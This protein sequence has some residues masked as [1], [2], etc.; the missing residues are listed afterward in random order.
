MLHTENLNEG[1]LLKRS[2]TFGIDTLA[3]RDKKQ[4]LSIFDYFI[5]KQKNCVV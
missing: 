4:T 2:I 5:E 1:S 3:L